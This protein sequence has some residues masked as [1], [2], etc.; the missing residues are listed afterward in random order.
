[1]IAETEENT[2]T[3]DPRDPED[4][5]EAG[6]RPEGRRVR[7]RW[8]IG[9]IT[10]VSVGAAAVAWQ[11][12]VG[13]R[14][15]PGPE[16]RDVPR[17]E[18][19]AILISDAYRKR[20]GIVLAAAERGA[21]TPVVRVV[22]TVTLDPRR[23]AAVGT[24]TPGFV[25]RVF[26]LEGDHVRSG[27]ALAEI[28]SAELGKAQAQVA[29]AHAQEYAARTNARREAALLSDHLTTA[30]E[31]EE[32][33]A[34]LA[35]RQ[36]SLAAAKQGVMAIGGDTD[37]P[38]GL[39]VLRSP[40]SGH[41]VGALLSVGQSVEA[42]KLAFRIADLDSVWVELDVFERTI[43]LVRVGD[44]VVVTPMADPTRHIK[45]S[46]AHVGELIDLSSRSADV[47]IQVDNKSRLLRPGQAVSALLRLSGP[48]HEALT[49]PS[50]AVTYID[51]TPMVFVATAS[52]RIVPTK[53]R[54]GVSDGA[55]DEI[56]SGLREGDQVVKAGV[57]ALKSELFR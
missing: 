40:I 2:G 56:L 41:V 55:R 46:V 1:M 38:L 4:P 48:G 18:N 44:S 43:G 13:A 54:L 35:S 36:A 51:D 6:A 14:Q 8:L 39:R 19:G 27:D 37:G 28:E 10:L 32:A 15:P 11:R 52:N 30:R 16:P 50:E 7:R 3:P 12:H 5:I 53:V 21:L 24:R 31:S 9:V 22:G 42:H 29:T 17:E 20:A 47:R 33:A 57:F 45:G 49:I 34:T 26:K 23:I 25:R